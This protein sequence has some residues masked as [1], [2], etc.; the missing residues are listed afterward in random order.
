MCGVMKWVAGAL[1][2]LAAPVLSWA[3]PSYSGSNSCLTSGCH[4]A[5]T[6][7]VSVTG[8]RTFDQSNRLDGLDPAAL[9]TFDVIA[10]N[11]V[12]IPIV[13]TD[14]GGLVAF[15]FLKGGLKNSQSNLLSYGAGVAS[16]TYRTS[17]TPNPRFTRSI[18]A[19]GTYAL[20]LP[21][22]AGTPA[23]VYE[24]QIQ[25][26]GKPSNELAQAQMIY[27]NVTTAP[28][29]EPGGLLGALPLAGMWLL[30][31]RRR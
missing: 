29:P 1:A 27:L 30:R 17:G 9:P 14:D 13:T 3:L 12:T 16:W 21:I 25:W 6:G 23:D 11:T 5:T 22:N 28:A 24:L 8:D 7:K 19:A 26:G 2:L 10:G 15:Q 4:S 20:A 18:G 31:R